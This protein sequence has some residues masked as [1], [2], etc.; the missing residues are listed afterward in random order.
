MRI[1]TAGLILAWF[2]L[3][4]G[5]DIRQRRLPNALTLPGA[6]LVLLGAA[7]AGRGLAAMAGAAV[8]GGVYLLVY[9]LAPAAMGAGD[10]KLAIGV[11]GLAGCF[12]I[13]VWFLAA[14]AAPL[15]TVLVGVGMRWRGMRTVPHGPSMCLATAG[16]AALI[17]LT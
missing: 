8:L 1:G 11:G 9:L 16:A 5:Y 2:A 7:A 10:V 6:V 13:Q 12:G 4:S 15:L 14:L 3:L 17:L